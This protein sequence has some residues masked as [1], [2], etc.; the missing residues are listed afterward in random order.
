[1]RLE[2]EVGEKCLR[3]RRAEFTL[4]SQMTLR[5]QMSVFKKDP[6]SEREA[7]H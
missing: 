1:M 4:A 5:L 3:E 7:T 6:H 2:S